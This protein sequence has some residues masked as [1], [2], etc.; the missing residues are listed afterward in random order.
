MVRDYNALSQKHID[1]IENL[2]HREAVKK[3]ARYCKDKKQTIR[4]VHG[5]VF[6]IKKLCEY[7]PDKS[8][9]DLTKEDVRDYFDSDVFRISKRPN[10][11]GTQKE[12]EQSTLNSNKLDIR[13]FLKWVHYR[14]TP[15][16]KKKGV[17]PDVV[18][19]I[20][21]VQDRKETTPDQ[22][23][24]EDEVM[25]MINSRDLLR[26][27]LFIALLY[28][29]G[30]R[31]G[32]ILNITE[33]MV[34]P[35]SYGFTVIL[36]GKTGPR[37]VR[38][39]MSVPYM[40]QY[41]QTKNSG[42]YLIR[43]NHGQMSESRAQAIVRQAAKAARIS[44]RA[45][46]HLFR[47]TTATR[48][49]SKLTEPELKAFAG[50]KS[51]SV[52]PGHYVHM[53]GAHIDGKLREIYGMKTEEEEMPSILTPVTCPRCHEVNAP[54]APICV[55]CT[56]NL[57]E[58]IPLKPESEVIRD[59]LRIR[60][61]QMQA[62]QKQ[63]KQMQEILDFQQYQREQPPVRVP[64]EV[65]ERIHAVLAGERYPPSREILQV[66]I[67]TLEMGEVTPACKQMIQELRAQLAESA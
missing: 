61:V 36:D 53:S 58:D 57:K 41:M 67:D 63:M 13:T 65:N 45:Y 40:K 27:R 60:D 25:A 5:K 18:D 23:F 24:T 14:D 43:T 9:E 20:E 28:D 10:K 26:D 37:P 16:M 44:R 30:G 15:M 66:Q 59:E 38:L 1:S 31:L 49:A 7:Y 51:D 56:M 55:K 3:Y 21:I 64:A 29:T 34:M 50:W 2:D 62:M 33:D 52:M 6:R 22:L 39:F 12:I 48:M 32:E 19:W 47:H 35:D 54:G 11:D 8:L 46:P 42:R 17:Y 4:T